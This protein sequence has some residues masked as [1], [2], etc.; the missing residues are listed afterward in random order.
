MLFCPELNIDTAGISCCFDK[1]SQGMLEDYRNKGL[2]GTAK[3]VGDVLAVRGLEGS[4]VLELGCGIGALALDLVRRGA[5]SAVGVDLSPKM[6]QLARSLA[7][8][9]GIS[10]S[11]RFELG[12][13]AAIRPEQA[14]IVV[15][16]KVLCCYPDAS[17]LLE[18][19]A[20]AARRLCAISIPDDGRLATKILRM[21][22]PLQGVFMRRGSFRFFI[23]SRRMI[24]ETLSR[25]GFRQVEAARVGWIWSVILFSSQAPA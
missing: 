12:D 5:S 9:A 21:L 25:K 19:S 2:D 4:K 1:E 23:P 11:A 24:N 18:N 17:A 8:E 13:G 16:D 22:L 14:D 3:I 20:S 7:A 6:I 15:L 10:D